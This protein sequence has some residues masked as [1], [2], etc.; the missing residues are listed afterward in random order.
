MY[1]ADSGDLH[2]DVYLVYLVALH[3]NVKIEQ[4][5]APEMML[6]RKLGNLNS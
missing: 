6:E 2:S 1:S 5:L 4:Y 3:R